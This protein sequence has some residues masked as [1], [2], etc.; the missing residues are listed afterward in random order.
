LR[1]AQRL[2]QQELRQRVVRMNQHPQQGWSG[3]L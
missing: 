3:S 1:R 2:H